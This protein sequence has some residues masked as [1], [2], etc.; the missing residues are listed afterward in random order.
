MKKKI[1]IIINPISGTGLQ[2]KAETAIHKLLDTH[3]LFDSEIVYSQQKGQMTLLAK[4]AADMAYDAVIVVGGDGSINEA[5]QGLIGTQTAMGIIPIGSGNG[6]A[7]HLKIPMSLEPA[8]ER[9]NQFQTK[10]IDTA[11]MN[12]HK[13]VSLAG[14][15][16]DAHIASQFS[17]AKK[18]GLWN[19]I[20]ISV[21][22]YFRFANKEYQ[23]HLDNKAFKTDAF[24]I[25]F[26]NANQ[27]GN[28]VVIS[29]EARIDD[30][31]LDV[32]VVKK[33]KA[34]QILGL[35]IKVLL[36]KAHKSKLVNI[37]R[38]KQITIEL[39]SSTF[40]NLDGESISESESIHIGV[41]PLSLS[42]IS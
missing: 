4:E 2:K 5:A 42:V 23:M 14:I 31:F 15:G 28:N 9:I 6:L 18:R 29:P 10:R 34:Y 25:V 32:C 19:Y 13:F 17:L 3:F 40:L 35:L 38:A 33:P 1:R 36:K 37:Q 39:K 21:R 24:M 41:N 20:K 26:A 22:E 12:N 8:V 7:R 11:E 30:G 27:F 16:F